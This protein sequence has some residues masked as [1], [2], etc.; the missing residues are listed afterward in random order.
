MTAT[1]AGTRTVAT[2]ATAFAAALEDL[3]IRRPFGISG[4]AGSFF[5][6]A[7]GCT[8]IGVAPF[9]HESGAAFAACEASIESGAPVVIFVTP[10][11]GLTNVLTG[12]YAARHEAAQVVL[13]SASTESAMYG[14]RPIQETGPR[15]L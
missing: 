13:V 2:F 9:R 10:G 3:G 4:G 15:T 12:I 6:S 8:G 11:P 7:L 14:R 1:P 5:W